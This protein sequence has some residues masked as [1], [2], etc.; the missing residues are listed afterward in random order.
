M[1]QPNAAGS[2]GND[3][4]PYPNSP[5]FGWKLPVQSTNE[6]MLVIGHGIIPAIGVY[7]H[8]TRLEN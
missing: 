2:D 4:G 6:E 3:G 5:G 1:F 7:I 8:G